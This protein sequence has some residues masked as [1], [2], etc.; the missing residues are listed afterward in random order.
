MK[1]IAYSQS[2][3]GRIRD[4]NEDSVAIVPPPDAE[5]ESRLGRL[6]VLADGMGGALAGEIASSHAV[7]TIA[8]NY[9][10]T[11]GT[12][13]EAL[14]RSIEAANTAVYQRAQNEQRMGMG[15]TVV[16]AAVAHDKL[17]VAHVGDSRLYLLRAGRIAALTRDHSLV[18]EQ[19]AAGILTP[20]EAGRH[21]HRNVISRAVGTFPHIEVE[22]SN[23]TGLALE[24]GDMVLICS[25][26]LTEYV[27]PNRLIEILTGRLPNEAAPLLI[28]AA[29]QG[30]GADNI[31]VIL[32]RVG[33]LSDEHAAAVTTQTEAR[34]GAVTETMRLPAAAAVATPAAPASVSQSTAPAPVA[35]KRSPWPALLALLLLL[36]VGGLLAYRQFGAQIFPPAVPSPT[37]TVAGG[38]LEGAGSATPT[39]TTTATV[40]R[41][42][43]AAASVTGAPAAGTATGDATSGASATPVATPTTTPAA[44]LGASGGSGTAV[45]SVAAGGVPQRQ[46]SLIEPEAGTQSLSAP[47]TFRAQVT[48][49][50]PSDIV[51]LRL[52]NGSRIVGR[53]RMASEANDLYAVAVP[54]LPLIA[55]SD[56]LWQVAVITA[57]RSDS[58]TTVIL[59]ED[60]ALTWQPALATSP[61]AT[62]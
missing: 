15:T 46:I 25:D 26:G 20:E 13:N 9:Y 2:D 23:N 24:E 58:K 39:T 45:A 43:T 41:T 40:S 34:G 61:T 31:S 59:S 55:D 21:P 19:V 14:V 47:L 30:G 8:E 42:V 62:P 51:Q 7:Y 37:A 27:K 52:K 38:I 1:L 60:F 18:A 32:I 29:N 6:Y 48:N 50:T 11:A 5:R 44:T 12:P 16:A 36:G 54:R 49:L 4:I 53:Y 35:R 57:D 28:D 3:L 33:E 10:Q 17:Y 56:L 22:L